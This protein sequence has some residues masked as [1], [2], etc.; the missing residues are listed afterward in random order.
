MDATGPTL[1]PYRSVAGRLSPIIPMAIA[2][3]GQWQAAD[4]YVDSGAFYTLVHAQLAVAYGL[5]FRKGRRLNVQVGDGSLIPI[6]LHRLP[7]QIGTMR[8]T[9]TIGFSEKLGVRFNLLGR[10][11][12]FDHFTICFH[13]RRKVVSFQPLS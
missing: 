9:A 11:D 3:N 7:V 10:Q 2:L 12:V 6:Y 13:E 4:L 1:F 8:F 5:D